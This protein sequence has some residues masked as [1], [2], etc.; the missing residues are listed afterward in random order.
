MFGFLVGIESNYQDCFCL[1][2]ANKGG[3]RRIEVCSWYLERVD[4]ALR[5]TEELQTMVIVY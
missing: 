2:P 1:G 5:W 4:I 3:Y